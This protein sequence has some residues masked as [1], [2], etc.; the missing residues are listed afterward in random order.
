MPQ[1]QH[2]AAI[3][4]ARRHGDSAT[5]V[6]QESIGWASTCSILTAEIAAIAAALD[7]V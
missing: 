7:Y 1:S 5:V 6:V 3:A 4:V 2:T